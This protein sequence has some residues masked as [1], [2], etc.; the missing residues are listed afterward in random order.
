MTESWQLQKQTKSIHSNKKKAWNKRSF[1][2]QR[3]LSKH[4]ALIWKI[5]LH[6][7]FHGTSEEVLKMNRF[8]IWKEI[9]K[10]NVHPLLFIAEVKLNAGCKQIFKTKLASMKE[11]ESVDGNPLKDHFDQNKRWPASWQ[12]SFLSEYSNQQGICHLF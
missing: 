1:N 8:F 9:N 6:I 11:I 10:F 2:V 7:S 5:C 4:N 3:V 12:H